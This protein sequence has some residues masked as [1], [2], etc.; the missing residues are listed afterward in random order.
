MYLQL[1]YITKCFILCYDED[2]NWNWERTLY[3]GNRGKHLLSNLYVYPI[4]MCKGIFLS[5]V[6]I[7]TTNALHMHTS[8]FG[9]TYLLS[10]IEIQRSNRYDF[11][12]ICSMWESAFHLY[13]LRLVCG[14]LVWHRECL[15]M[16]LISVLLCKNLNPLKGSF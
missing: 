1:F 7:S 10:Y 13:L 2:C 8:A 4:E 3:K 5:S 11:H 6:H 12:S 9:C 14:L 16:S 15:L